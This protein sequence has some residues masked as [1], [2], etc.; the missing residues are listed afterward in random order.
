MIEPQSNN[1]K[2]DMKQTLILNSKNPYFVI[3]SVNSVLALK[4]FK[5]S[6]F[7]GLFKPN[8]ISINL[9]L[10]QVLKFG[11]NVSSRICKTS[12]LF[13]GKV[14]MKTIVPSNIRRMSSIVIT[15]WF[16]SPLLFIN[17]SVFDKIEIKSLIAPKNLFWAL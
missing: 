1:N 14:Q 2:S 4:S 15:S 16:D 6:Y 11:L 9:K 13:L 17:F 3:L 5:K 7:F 10:A 12:T 8:R